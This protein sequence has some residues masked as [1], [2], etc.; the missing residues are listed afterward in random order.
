MLQMSGKGV[1]GL[2]IAAMDTECM[3]LPAWWCV[4]ESAFMAESRKQ[5]QH[6]WVVCCS[7]NHSWLM[8]SACL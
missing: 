4:V 5:D 7:R 1:K 6:I 3:H 2:K 8:D